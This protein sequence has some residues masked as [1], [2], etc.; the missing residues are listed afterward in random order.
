MAFSS[1]RIYL[2][3]PKIIPAVA[4]EVAS[5]LEAEGFT[6]KCVQSIVGDADISIHKGGIFKAILGMKTALK[7]HL[8]KENGYIKADAKVGIFGQQFVPTVIS[9]MIFWP[10]LITQIWGLIKQ[11]K[12]DD[13]VLDLVAASCNRLKA[14]SKEYTGETGGFCPECGA[15]ASGKFCSSC[16]EKLN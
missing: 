11:S 3:N 7:V 8:Y 4:R 10:V 12:L 9:V 6:V 14:A 16:G 15:A 5:Q 1:S 2:F 13:H